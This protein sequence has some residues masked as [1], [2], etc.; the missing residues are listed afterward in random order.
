MHKIGPSSGKHNQIRFI[1]TLRALH[2]KVQ[3]Q[4]LRK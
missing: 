2:H 1:H 3:F 4:L